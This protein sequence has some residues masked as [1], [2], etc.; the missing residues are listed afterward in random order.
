M[1][2]IRISVILSPFLS[3]PALDQQLYPDWTWGPGTDSDSLLYPDGS[4]GS[5]FGQ[6][7][8]LD[9]DA[10]WD[11]RRRLLPWNSQR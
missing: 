7:S 8:E 11:S 10:S 3:V 5:N 1:V 9:Q 4:W 2:G 6:G